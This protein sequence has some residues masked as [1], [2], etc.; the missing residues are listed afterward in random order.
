MKTNIPSI[1]IF[2]KLGF[3]KYEDGDKLKFEMPVL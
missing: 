2:E 3:N 1:K